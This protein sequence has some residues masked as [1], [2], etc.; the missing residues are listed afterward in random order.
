MAARWRS[1]AIRRSTRAFVKL[2][3]YIVLQS[4]TDEQIAELR[5]LLDKISASAPRARYYCQMNPIE[6]LRA[7]IAAPRAPL[8]MGVVNTTPDSFYPESRVR[9][10]DEALLRARQLWEAGADIIDIGGESTRPGAAPVSPEEE[11][12]RVLPVIEACRER[13]P[14]PISIDTRNPLT[15][16]RAL[17][18]GAA[19]INDITALADPAMRRLAAGTSAFVIL[20][21]MQGT[22]ETMQDA[23]R[24]AS[25]VDEVETFLRARALDALAAGIERDKI[26]LDPGIGFGKTTG[27]NL[28]LIAAIPRLAALGYPVLAGFSR[29]SFIAE[30]LACVPA[31]GGAGMR[32]DTRSAATAGRAVSDSDKLLATCLYNYAALEHGARILRVHDARET[33]ITVRVW[34]SLLFYP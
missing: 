6:T 33:A 1:G 9:G 20:M 14:L 15:A 12:R 7:K 23:P 26:W 34:R 19:I 21:H 4:G 8:I 29:K 13:I 27:D 24:Y 30:V 25:V 5:K 2:R 32:Q 28:A 31:D 11:C 10:I 3:Q 18:A 16:E 22:P 17:A